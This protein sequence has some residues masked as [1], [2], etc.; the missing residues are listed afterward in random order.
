[1]EDTNPKIIIPLSTYNRLIEMEI[2]FK[3]NKMWIEHESYFTGG[4]GGRTVHGI[5]I[6]SKD[7]LSKDVEIKNFNDEI[8]KLQKT[9][10]DRGTELYELKKKMTKKSCSFF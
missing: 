9:L 1:M 8:S 5:V 7:D 4:I 10:Y 3:E 2:A 6:Y